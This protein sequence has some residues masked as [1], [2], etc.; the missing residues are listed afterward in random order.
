MRGEPE[1]EEKGACGYGK[2]YDIGGGRVEG[3][4]VDVERMGKQVDERDIQA[5]VP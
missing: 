2:R 1:P 4:P 3:G 5:R